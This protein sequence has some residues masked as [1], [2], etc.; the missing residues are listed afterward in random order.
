MSNK[1][2]R[3][4]VKNTTKQDSNL[5]NIVDGVVCI[6]EQA[7]VLRVVRKAGLKRCG[8]ASG[9]QRKHWW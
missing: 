5:R 2:S 3:F 6:H 8:V 4:Q 1:Y 7:E 9:L